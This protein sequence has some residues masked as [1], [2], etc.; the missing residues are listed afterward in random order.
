MSARLIKQGDTASVS[1]FVPFSIPH[2]GIA[3]AAAV[4]PLSIPL[5]GYETPVSNRHATDK[6][7]PSETA[8]AIVEAARHEAEQ[9]IVE[10][11]TRAEQIQREAQEKTVV[12]SRAM[13]AEQVEAAIAPLLEKFAQSIEE[14]EGLRT[15]ISRRAERDMIR[16]S[17][18]IARKIIHRE[19]SVDHEIALTLAKVALSRL[20]SRAIARV[21][22]HPD[23]ALY[24]NSHLDRLE[25]SGTVEVV[26][27]RS[28]G[29]GGCL[30]ETEMGDLDARIEQQFAEIEREFLTL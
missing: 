1:S 9:I 8:A 21:R 18:E 22:L 13:A 11:N 25:S 20:H 27:D 28:V 14:I 19:V 29:R 3:A 12:Q 5:T 16:L 2:T 26:A 15:A 4:R 7:K 24:V 30:V 10:A 23:D 17:L 6:A